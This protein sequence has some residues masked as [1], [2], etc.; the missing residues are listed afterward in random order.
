MVR[1]GTLPGNGYGSTA[2]PVIQ[3]I[4]ST[5]WAKRV[6]VRP[7]DG[8]GTVT[9][10]N[11]RIFRAHGVTWAGFTGGGW[12]LDSS[13]NAG[14]AW[15]ESKG[16]TITWYTTEGEPD[17]TGLHVV[18]VVQSQSFMRDADS[19]D[20]WVK[21]GN[22]VS[23]V[24]EGLYLAP[25]WRAAGS[26][27]HS[28]TLQFEPFN[29]AVVTNATLRDCVMFGSRNAVIQINA[30]RTATIDHCYLAARGYCLTRYPIPSGGDPTTSSA[31]ALNGGHGTPA[32]T[33]K[34]SA[35][36]GQWKLDT[37]GGPAV[38]TVTNTIST[39]DYSSSWPGDYIVHT[40]LTDDNFNTVTGLS[41]PGTPGV[42]YRLSDIWT[43]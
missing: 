40:N 23:P 12:R 1:P 19:T 7:R 28:D 13:I 8:F 26:T 9:V 5:S 34:D 4:G 15:I 6:L 16:G 11:L 37:D 20:C 30:L 22:L 35:I 32:L 21:G 39:V 29:G 24:F 3:D 33:V 10:G 18:D 36:M 17:M 42:D 41:K 25:A 2:T 14:Q 38:S 27:Q 43:T 31:W